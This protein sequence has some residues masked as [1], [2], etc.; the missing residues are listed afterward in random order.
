MRASADYVAF[1]V[2]HKQ[3]KGKEK[4]CGRKKGERKVV[5]RPSSAHWHFSF[6]FPPGVFLILVQTGAEEASFHCERTLGSNI[7]LSP[8]PL[9]SIRQ[10]CLK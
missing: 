9:H 10:V 3:S 5:L 1:C 8:V 6:R 4:N 2:L 7:V